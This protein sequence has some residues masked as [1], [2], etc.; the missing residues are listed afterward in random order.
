VDRLNLLGFEW[1]MSD[2]QV[3]FL[4][5]TPVQVPMHATTHPRIRMYVHTLRTAWCHVIGATQAEPFPCLQLTLMYCGLPPDRK[6]LL[7][8]K[9]AFHSVKKETLNYKLPLKSTTTGTGS[10]EFEQAQYANMRTARWCQA[11]R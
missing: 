9:A 8:G 11:K 10:S 2:V 1:T 4:P 3:G 6:F 5:T 7:A